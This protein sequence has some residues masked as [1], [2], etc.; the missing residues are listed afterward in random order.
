MKITCVKRAS[1]LGLT[2]LMLAIGSAIA[3]SPAAAQGVGPVGVRQFHGSQGVTAPNPS[4][5]LYRD[6]QQPGGL[7][8]ANQAG[9]S[10]QVGS[11]RPAVDNEPIDPSIRFI[12]E[13]LWRRTN[14][15]GFGDQGTLGALGCQRSV[16]RRKRELGAIQ[17]WYVYDYS[18]GI[19]DV[20]T[21][22]GQFT[23]NR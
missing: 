9:S 11:V 8:E 10:S 13:R 22:T 2:G 15:L 18:D 7:R 17:A 12:E 20:E 3:T 23:L 16:E 14:V 1:L 21:C 4:V 5:R 6:V 19:V